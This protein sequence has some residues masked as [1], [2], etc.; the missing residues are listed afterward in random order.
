LMSTVRPGEER[1]VRRSRAAQVAGRE[2][3]LHRRRPYAE[4]VHVQALDGVRAARAPAGRRET[5]ESGAR[6]AF[7]RRRRIVADVALDFEQKNGLR[8]RVVLR[9]VVAVDTRA[10]RV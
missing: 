9:D 10:G 1:V 6:I 4:A 3:E 2:L 8:R 7:A 5:V